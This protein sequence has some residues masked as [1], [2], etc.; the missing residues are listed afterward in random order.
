MMLLQNTATAELTLLRTDTITDSEEPFDR[1]VY[2]YDF[3]VSKQGIIHA[4]Y[5]KPVPSE[6][7]TQIIYT[8]K[9][10]GDPWPVENQRLILEEQ[11][12]KDSISTWIKLDANGV[13]HISYIVARDFIDKK[14]DKHKQGLVYQT[15]NNGI[16]SSKI[17]ISPG[18]FNTRMQLNRENKAIFAR[19]IEIYWTADGG[20][21]PL[22]F[23]KGLALFSPALN[24]PDTWQRIIL[25]LPAAVDYRLANFLYD[26]QRNRFHIAYGDHDAVF[27]RDTYPTTNPPIGKSSRPVVFPAGSGHKLWYAYSDNVYNEQA[28]L[29][30]NA[31]WN[32]SLVDDSGNLSENE[33]W[34]DLVLDNNGKPIMTSYRYATDDKGIQQGSTNMVA[35]FN[36][37]GWDRQIVAGK[38]KG[39]APSRAGMGAKLLVNATGEVHAI[40]DNSPDKPIDAENPPVAGQKASGTTMY[41]YSPDGIKWEA[42]RQV[43]LPFSVEGSIRAKLHNGKLL[44]MDLG[45]ARNARVIF[46]EY[47]V[48]APDD[49]LL[50]ISSDKMFYAPGETIKMHARIQGKTT[51]DF[52]VVVA[53]PYDRNATGQLIPVSTTFQMFYLR[54]D[55][56]WQSF[57]DF[58]TIKPALSHFPL[59]KLD[60]D[61]AYPMAKK[62]VPF[63]NPSRYIV[64]SAVN[65]SGNA[66]GDFL[67]PVYQYEIHICNQAACGEL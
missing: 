27:L 60:V 28:V 45:D 38:T 56:S 65:S 48:P 58:T 15:I 40:W 2:S 54:S 67:T 33:F 14:G 62:T 49:N 61:F 8:T 9:K 47:K 63:A 24:Q 64:Y 3:D 20:I 52:Y 55:L 41:R 7:R 42:V 59:K 32:A 18:A 1:R 50:E 34:T 10:M 23:P 37:T 4:V 36:G 31:I 19:E 53:G 30:T 35:H 29:N 12:F 26:T 21:R 66:L 44:V 22:P 5:A 39:A 25:N 11:G 16:V 46:S 13:A 57:S 51:G 43:L 6:A 17:N